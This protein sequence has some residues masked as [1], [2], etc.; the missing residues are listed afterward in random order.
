MTVSVSYP[1]HFQNQS[2][3]LTGQALL[4]G[5]WGKHQPPQHRQNT[6]VS[7]EGRQGHGTW[8]VNE[9]PPDR[10][11]GTARS[12]RAPAFLRGFVHSW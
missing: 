1:Y 12:G 11:D 4:A 8:G 7:G 6:Y 2:G 3:H 9:V 10:A 5:K